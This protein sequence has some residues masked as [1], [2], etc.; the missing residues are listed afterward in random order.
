ME[1]PELGRQMTSLAWN[2]GLPLTARWITEHL[3]AQEE[4]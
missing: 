1:Y 3:L 4:K 2:D